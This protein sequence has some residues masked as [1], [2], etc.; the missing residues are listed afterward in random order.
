MIARS[1]SRS[2]APRHHGS[3]F[4]KVKPAFE[5]GAV[6]QEEE[7]FN[8]DGTSAESPRRDKYSVDE[9]LGEERREFGHEHEVPE[10]QRRGGVEKV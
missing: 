7:I 2:L 4:E 1:V 6:G 3:H 9:K 8:E 10:G 5:E